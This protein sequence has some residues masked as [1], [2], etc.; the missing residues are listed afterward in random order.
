MMKVYK[1]KLRSVFT[2]SLYPDR[3][4]IAN[5]FADAEKACSN[6]TEIISIEKISDKAIVVEKSVL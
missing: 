5:S 2:Q 1:V 3:I 4:V 6:I